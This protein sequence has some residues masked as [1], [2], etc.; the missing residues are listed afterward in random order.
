ML[1]DSLSNSLRF[2]EKMHRRENLTFSQ[3]VPIILF[4]DISVY[5][6]IG[7]LNP[8]F[9]LLRYSSVERNRRFPFNLI[10]SAYNTIYLFSIALYIV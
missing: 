2:Q 9:T 1:D 7:R 4:S 10:S 8:Q 5:A 3:I 6:N